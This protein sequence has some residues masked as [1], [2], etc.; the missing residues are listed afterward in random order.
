MSEFTVYGVLGS[1]YLRAVLLGLEEK[2][3]PYR[4][5]PLR[6]GQ[7]RQAEHLA[8]QPFGRVP[9][10]EHGDFKLYEAQAV[11]RYLDRLFPEPGLTPKDPR[12][13]ARM[14][15]IMG[16][17]DWYLMPHLSGPIVF[18]RVVAPRFGVPCDEARLQDALPKAKV[19]VDEL[20][21]LLG[22]QPFMA[23]EALSLAD[24]MVAPQL[25]M[26]PHCPEGQ[27][28]L[29]PHPGLRAW[30][31]RMDQRPSLIATTWERLAQTQQA[32]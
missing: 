16:I 32:A 8:R 6:P 5:V 12:K 15:Q 7:N 31:E 9:A 29:A 3:R 18:Q 27:A 25:S 2:G 21:R 4:V 30:I 13:A 20:A 17:A 19:C 22:D 1:P 24:L 10:V 28:L 23:G 14:D 26:A 11:L